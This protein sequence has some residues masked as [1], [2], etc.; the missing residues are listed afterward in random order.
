[1]PNSWPVKKKNITFIGKPNC[2]SHKLDYVVSV[3]V[4]LRDVLNYAS[5]AKEAKQIIH[6]EEVLVNGK[7]INDV[8]FA[9]GIFDVLEIKKTSEKFTVLFNEFGRISLVPTKDNLIYLKITNKSTLPKGKIQLNFM[10]GF[11]IIVDTK[12]SNG[13]NIG[14][15]V[16]YDFV[17]KAIKSTLNLKQGNFVYI[18]D[19]KF[20]GEFA[21]VEGFVTYNGLAKDL[22]KIEISGNVHSTAKEYCYVIGSKAADIGRFQ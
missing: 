11:N 15:T 1:M 19:G 20:K 16:V 4:V 7:R 13:L 22:V 2:G 17:K 3:L 21:K 10:N 9:V 5:T 12:V 18:F 8:K 6:T 14:D